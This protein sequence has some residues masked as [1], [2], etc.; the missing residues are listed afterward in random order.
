M[1]SNTSLKITRESRTFPSETFDF[2]GYRFIPFGT[3]GI[4][5][6]STYFR[7]P[8]KEL[9]IRKNSLPETR[10][11]VCKTCQKLTKA[12]TAVY[13]KRSGRIPIYAALCRCN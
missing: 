12:G 6:E 3:K 13:V 1:A 2:A 11:N 10:R 9:V 8:R 4:T 5:V 7:M